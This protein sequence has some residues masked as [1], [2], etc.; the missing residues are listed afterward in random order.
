MFHKLRS[1]TSE[2]VS[3][4]FLVAIT[5]V[6]MFTVLVSASSLGQS[7]DGSV[8]VAP[9]QAPACSVPASRDRSLALVNVVVQDA[10]TGVPVTT[11]KREDFRVFDNRHEVS[12]SNFASGANLKTRP[13][14]LWLVV[15][16]NEH[17]RGSGGELASGR[18][19]GKESLFRPALNDL[20]KS[21][22]V[23]V[24]HWCDDGTAQIDLQPGIDREAAIATLQKVLSP[25]SYEGA[26]SGWTR[27]GEMTLQRTVRLVLEHSGRELVPV[28][29][30]LHNDRTG[31]PPE[32]LDRLIDDLRKM[33]SIVY[34]I[35]DADVDEPRH[36]FFLN[37][38][39][40]AVLHYMAQETGGMYFSVRPPAY[41]TVLQGI[42]QTVHFRFELGFTPS[43]ADD[44][45]HELKIELTGDARKGNKTA[46]L[47][48]YAEYIP[49]S[50]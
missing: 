20:D 27:K 50:H 35:K 18:F 45:R 12:I 29:V 22:R 6:A 34:G 48:Y 32:E 33:S 44:K 30:F 14:A 38:E 36:G 28:L 26:P 47:A 43:E 13:V 24:A 3:Q 19:A 9:A 4:P 37:T 11:L 5:M 16:C 8:A 31:M 17:G 10:K 2:R 49:S 46:Q 15:I 21:D 41:A 23:G 39:R 7:S 40:S 1:L 42:L 25:I